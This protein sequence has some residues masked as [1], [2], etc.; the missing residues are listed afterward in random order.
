IDEVQDAPREDLAA[1]A[2]AFQNLMKDELPVALAFAGLTVGTRDLFDLPGTT[3]LRRASA[4]ELGRLTADAAANLLADTADGSLIHF[5]DAAAR[6]AGTASFGFPYFVQLIVALACRVT[7]D[8]LKEEVTP[9][10]LDALHK[11]SIDTF[12]SHVHRPALR[13]VTD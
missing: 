7:K 13:H 12:G 11:E 8:Q 3:F 4:Y 10:T 9:E 5:G 6:R 1:V 2:Q